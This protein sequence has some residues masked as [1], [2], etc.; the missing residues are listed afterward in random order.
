MNGMIWIVIMAMLG[1]MSALQIWMSKRESRWP[2]LILP[3]IS[4]AVSVL[5]V[6]NMAEIPGED[7]GGVW[8]V[9]AALLLYNLPTLVLL[10]VYFACRSSMRRGQKRQM[11]KMHIQDLE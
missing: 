7:A 11:D 4:L 8:T 5:F 1:G 3:A 2:G 9:V 10:A 6:L